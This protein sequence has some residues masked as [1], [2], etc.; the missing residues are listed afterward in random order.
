MNNSAASTRTRIGGAILAVFAVIVAIVPAVMPSAPVSAAIGTPCEGTSA[1]DQNSLR[2]IPSHGSVFYIDSGQNVDASYMSYKVQN[3]AGAPR[4]DLFVGVDGFTGGVIRLANPADAVQPLGVIAASGSSTGFFLVKAP[5]STSAAQSH[6]VRVYQGRPGTLGSQELYSCTY[7]FAKVAETIKAAAN[8]VTSIVSTAVSTVG[9]T[10]TITVQ[11]A[12]GTVGAGSAADGSMVWLSPVAR[13][14]WPTGA[15]RLE[16]T[17]LR[18]FTNQGRTQELPTSPYVD[19]LRVPLSSG[20]KYYYTAVYTFR[21][22]G[23]SAVSSVPVVPIAQIASGTQIKHTDLG[24]ISSTIN[25]STSAVSVT[26]SKSV[27]ST[28]TVAADGTTTLHYEVT[29]RNTGAAVEVDQI[30][31]EPASQLSLEP[32]SV[33]VDGAAVA[34][35]AALVDQPGHL[36]FSGPFAVP[37]GTSGSPSTVTL[38]YSMVAAPCDATFSYANRATATIGALTIGS[39]ASTRSVTTAGGTCGDP[40]ITVSTVDEPLPMLAT[41]FPA[42]SITTSG[43]TLNG[44]VDSNGVAGQT[45]V[46]EYS[47]SPTLAGATTVTVGSTTTAA[48]AVATSSTLTG[49]TSG[50]VYYYRVGAGTVRGEILSFSTLEVAST[51]TAET[52]SATSVSTSGATLNGLVD[53]NLVANGAKVKFEY[54]VDLSGGACT[55]RGSTTTTGFLQSETDTSTEDAVLFG[56]F[57]TEVGYTLTGLTANTWY[58]YRVVALYNAA[59]ATWSTSVPSATWASFR[60]VTRSTQTIAFSPPADV[61][62][63]S[64]ALAGATATSGLT[65]DYTSS[66]PEVCTVASDGTITPIAEGVCSITANQPGS[67]TVDAAPPATVTFLVVRRVQTISFPAMADTVVEETSQAAAV[68]SAGLAPSY[69]SETPEICSVDSIGTVTALSAGECRITASQSGTTEVAPADPVTVAFTVRLPQTITFPAPASIATASTTMAG[70]STSATGLV[71]E[72]DT[73]TPLICSVSADGTITGLNV[74]TCRIRARQLGSELYA[75]AEPVT[76]TAAITAGPPIVATTSV[77][78]GRVGDFYDLTL[79][80]GGGDGTFTAWTILD[81]AL[82]AGLSLDPATGTISGEPTEAGDFLVTV[83][84]ESGGLTSAPQSLSLHVAKRTHSLAADDLEA[85]YG[86]DALPAGV[87][88]SQSRPI[89]LTSSDPTVATIDGSSI[90]VGSVGVATITAESAGTAL[91]DDAQTITFTVTVVAATLVITAPDVSLDYGDPVPSFEPTITGYVNGEGDDVLLTAPICTSD[92][93]ADTDADQSPPVTCSGASAA[94]YV[95]DYRAG[96]VAISRIAQTLAIDPDPIPGLAPGAQVG[97]TATSTSGL[98]VV[99]TVEGDCAWTSGIL[100]AGPTEGTCTVTASLGESTNYRAADDVVRTVE[101]VAGAPLSRALSLEL[102]PPAAS[103]RLDAIVTAVPTLS[104]AVGT[105]VLSTPDTAAVCTV[106]PDGTITLLTVGLCTIEAAVAADTTYVAAHATMSFQVTR[107]PRTLPLTASTTSAQRPD[108]IALMSAPSAGT[109][110]VRYQVI[111]GTEVCAL[112]G[113]TVIGLRA[114]AC[115]VRSTIDSDARYVSATSS[116]LTLTF[117]DP[118]VAPPSGL[119]DPVVDIPSA[120]VEPGSPAALPS[121]GSDSTRPTGSTPVVMPQPVGGAIIRDYTESAVR[122]PGELAGEVISGFAPGSGVVTRVT[123]SLSVGQFVVTP[124]S[125]GDPVGVALGIEESSARLGTDFGSLVG[126]T[127]IDPPDRTRLLSRAVTGDAFDT[128][129]AAGL[130][131]PMSVGGLDVSSG[132]VWLSATALAIDYVP[133]S[134]VYLAVTTSPI[135]V[136]ASVV[137]DDGSATVVGMVPVDL[138]ESGGHTL[139]LVGTR[140]LDGITTG[141]DGTVSVSAEALAEIQ[142]FDEGTTATVEIIGAGASGEDRRVVRIIPLSADVPWWSIIL[143]GFVIVVS[144][145]WRRIPISS[146]VRRRQSAVWALAATTVIPLLLGWLTG[147]YEIMAWGLALGGIAIVGH[148]VVRETG[149]R[150]RAVV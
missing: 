87:R 75:P 95:M 47:T 126:V 97:V 28:S 62:L 143:L 3:L 53:P 7:T 116:S 11:G 6:V 33:T 37:A 105:V 57:P 145:A 44:M 109:G 150:R 52:T 137:G 38:R 81:G 23:A 115:T 32:G 82:P 20:T 140:T 68:S 92:Y 134:V 19:Q 69:S 102:A 122:T 101:V 74:G 50:A 70:A 41:T 48:S 27:S 88:S 106:A 100:T 139:R 73:L 58:C 65:V 42:T 46:F 146:A 26:A 49:L 148:L 138:L 108:T 96:I 61:E 124:G 63:G 13:S 12:T 112:S 147:H 127:A 18:L 104:P 78:D 99:I 14:S 98:P 56:A 24:S 94:N 121:T 89:T 72:Y 30:V 40:A 80:A 9:S 5:S 67:S 130:D 133:G 22:I 141:S 59:S 83:T 119:S 113:A 111:S 60:A 71:V 118:S 135:I 43:A 136:G 29:L 34:D 77:E 129:R 1:S 4:S 114:G 54:A 16:T 110:T 128:F 125:I 31:D 85:T 86:D 15:L 45:I 51:P 144:V 64:S 90:I 79:L 8:K 149:V 84:V 142:R 36:A 2:V 21:I 107:L 120:P 35:G 131:S 123:G 117:S 76:Q 132:S 91:I 66:T 93:S 55:T 25:P 10:M 39:S 103:H 17:S